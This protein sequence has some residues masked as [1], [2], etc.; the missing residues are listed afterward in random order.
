VEL[1]PPPDSGTKTSPGFLDEGSLSEKV[2]NAVLM[3][4]GWLVIVGV[5]VGLTWLFFFYES[6]GS[7]REDPF[8]G[9][10]GDPGCYQT[11]DGWEC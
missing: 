9:G 2:F 5:I 7:S 4:I 6:G 8:S 10:G 3:T 1:P 11:A